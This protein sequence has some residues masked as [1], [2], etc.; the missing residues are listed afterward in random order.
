MCYTVLEP[1][2]WN[3]LVMSMSNPEQAKPVVQED[4][5]F[6]QRNG[7]ACRLTV[8]TPAWY[9]W[10]S[11]ATTFAFRSKVGTFTA[12]REQ[13]GHKRGGWYWRAYRKRA[14]Q[15]HRAYLGPS[16]ELTL[17]WL[18]TIAAT[19][20]AQD[21]I[22][23]DEQEPPQ[24][25]LQGHPGQQEHSRHIPTDAMRQMAEGGAAWEIIKRPASTLPLPLTSLIGRERE[26][27]A[28][29]TLLVR[30]EVR[31]LTLTGTGGVGKTRLALAS[32]TEVQGD[33]PDGVCFVSLAPLS[34]PAL[35]LPT[36]AQT[37]GLHGSRTRSPLEV[38]QAAL[39]EQQLLLVLDNFE[40]VVQ[41]APSL[42]ELLAAC[43][44]LKLL[45][46][47]ENASLSSRR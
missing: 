28:A 26:V 36:I 14:G 6:Y 41:A 8:G 46:C 16:E 20:A 40:Q 21:T 30:P 3:H 43:P 17:E 32:A 11:T 22:T 10:L 42:V 4:T 33:F 29:C 27:A 25:V 13:A 18:R 38:L 31:L 9:A 1:L 7:Q 45:V 23:G 19:L 34:D 35:V 44:R 2:S 47:G 12:R 37:L 15:L 24:G 5:L 39:H